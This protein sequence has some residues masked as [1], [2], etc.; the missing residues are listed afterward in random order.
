MALTYTVAGVLRGTLR[1]EPAGRLAADLG[2]RL[3]ALVFVV[4]AFSMF[5]YYEL[6]MPRGV[7][8]RL[9]ALSN[10]Q[11]AEQLHRHVRDGRA[12]GA[13]RD[14]LRHPAAGRR[15]LVIGQAG[16]PVRGGLALFALSMGMGMPLLLIGTS[17]GKLLPRAGGW[18][19]TVK[20]FFGV[21][22]LGVALWF[23]RILAARGSGTLGRPAPHGSLRAR[24]VR[25]RASGSAHA[26]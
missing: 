7:Q 15:A 12:F 3:F 1:P 5:G 20:H 10:Q 25:A 19:D 21:L 26:G 11:K 9:A 16:D 13:H 4:L 17:L 22:L 8:S 14:H 2:A 6:Q 24:R 23:A 18:M